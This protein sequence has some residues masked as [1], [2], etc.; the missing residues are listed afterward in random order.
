VLDLGPALLDELGLI[1]ALKMYTSQF[2]TRTGITVSLQESN[3]PRNLP[4][5]HET[6]VYRVIQGALSNVLKHARATN[7]KIG[8][9]KAKAPIIVLTIEDNGIGFDVT[10][11]KT[12]QA[13]GLTAIRERIEGLGGRFRLESWPRGSRGRKHGTRI[14]V[15]LPLVDKE[16]ENP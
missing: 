1:P 4:S 7:V 14:E 16:T 5:A 10:R 9:T 15:N 11:L 2:A 6:V 8:M 13:F 12:N 3:I